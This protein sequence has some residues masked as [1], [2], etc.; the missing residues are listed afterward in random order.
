MH[1]AMI[2]HNV[3]ARESMMFGVGYVR[4]RRFAMNSSVFFERIQCD[5]R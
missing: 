1:I 4:Q 5:V 2:G 3:I